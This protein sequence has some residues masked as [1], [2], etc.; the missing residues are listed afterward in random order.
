MKIYSHDGSKVHKMKY[1]LLVEMTRHLFAIQILSVASESDF[2]TNGRI[3][4]SYRSCLLHYT[5]SYV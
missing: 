1:P 5:G 4:K 2:N 3:L